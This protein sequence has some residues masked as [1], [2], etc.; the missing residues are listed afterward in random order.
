MRMDGVFRPASGRVPLPV[1]STV[2]PITVTAMTRRS[3]V[4]PVEEEPATS[5]ALEPGGAPLAGPLL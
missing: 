5:C 3:N 2:L 4:S 1:V